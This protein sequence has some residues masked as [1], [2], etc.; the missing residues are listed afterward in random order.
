MMFH[1]KHDVTAEER[2]I[3]LDEGINSRYNFYLPFKRYVSKSLSH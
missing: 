1:I 2:H 3:M